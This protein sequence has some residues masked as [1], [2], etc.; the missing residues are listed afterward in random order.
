M[1]KNMI[2]SIVAV[3]A[4]FFLTAL[5]SLG[6][7]VVLHAI[8]VFPPWGQ[9]MSDTLFVLATTYRVVYTVAGGYLTARLA[10]ERPMRHVVV[11]GCI[12]L[13]V[14]TLGAALTW[15]S[16]PELGPKWYPI[17]LVVTALPCVWLGGRLHGSRGGRLD[18]SVAVQ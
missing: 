9:P 1:K 5:L 16:G 17:L 6:T 13:V 12:G 2:A 3:G 15:N 4:G 10:P 7:D 8:G 18:Q 11:L 14:A